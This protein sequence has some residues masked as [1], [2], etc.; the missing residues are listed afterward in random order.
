MWFVFVLVAALVFTIVFAKKNNDYKEYQDKEAARHTTQHNL[1]IL[2]TKNEISPP[3]IDPP[4]TKAPDAPNQEH[5][6]EPRKEITLFGVNG[7]QWTFSGKAL[8]I[9]H[10]NKITKIPTH[11]IQNVELKLPSRMSNGTI[12]IKTGQPNSYVR[13]T[14][15]VSLGLG[16]EEFLVFLPQ[17]TEIA[18]KLADAL[19][20]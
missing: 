3:R 5:A 9:Q 16:G 20:E 15:G 7:G 13:M 6:N 12:K 19:S 4:A 8:T 11:S 2:K 18:E 17:E 14:P 1:D 10:G